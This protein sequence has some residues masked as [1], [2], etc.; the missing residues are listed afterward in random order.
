[1]PSFPDSLAQSGARFYGPTGPAIHTD[2][3]AAAVL[4]IS[5]VLSIRQLLLEFNKNNIIE[6]RGFIMRVI[7]S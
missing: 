6:L 4:W 7:G 1:M 5:L 3:L 2:L